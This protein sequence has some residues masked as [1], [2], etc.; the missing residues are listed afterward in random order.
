MNNKDKIIEELSKQ[1]TNISV[2]ASTSNLINNKNK[3]FTIKNWKSK[4]KIWN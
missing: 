4:F 1:L 2:I 3:D